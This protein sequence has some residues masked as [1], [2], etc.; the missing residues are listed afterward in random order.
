MHGFL[1]PYD[2]KGLNE[3]LVTNGKIQALALGYFAVHL[4]YRTQ[5]DAVKEFVTKN[6]NLFK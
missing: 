2:E 6:H 1:V 4:G 5:K 3:Y